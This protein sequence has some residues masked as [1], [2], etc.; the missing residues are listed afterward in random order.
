[1]AGGDASAGVR[2]GRTDTLILRV[3]PSIGSSP[4]KS[5]KGRHESQCH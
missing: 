1:M 2:F 5:L 3:T 4:N